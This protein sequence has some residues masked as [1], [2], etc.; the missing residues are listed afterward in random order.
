VEK[1]YQADQDYTDIPRRSTIIERVESIQSWI[2]ASVLPLYTEQITIPPASMNPAERLISTFSLYS[3]LKEAEIE[4][5]YQPI[6][7][8][9]Q[10]EWQYVGGLVRSCFYLM[11]IH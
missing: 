3:E 2:A 5:D 6:F 10:R 8:R 1:E 4:S 11:D 7:E 9:L